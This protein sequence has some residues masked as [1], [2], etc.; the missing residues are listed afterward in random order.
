[1]KDALLT[2]IGAVIGG[3]G[4]D[5]GGA[6]AEMAE[7]A[8]RDDGEQRSCA[9]VAPLPAAGGAAAEAA[10]AAAAAAEQLGVARPSSGPILADCL[11]DVLSYHNGP[12]PSARQSGM[13]HAVAAAAADNGATIGVCGSRPGGR[14]RRSCARQ[15]M[16]DATD[17][18]NAAA[19]LDTNSTEGPWVNQQARWKRAWVAEGCIQDF[20]KWSDRNLAGGGGA[21]GAAALPA[22]WEAV[23]TANGISMTFVK[24]MFQVMCDPNGVRFGP[25]FDASV[26][27]DGA[28]PTY[29]RYIQ[30]GLRDLHRIRCAARSLRLLCARLPSACLPRGVHAA[31]PDAA[32]ACHRRPI[33]GWTS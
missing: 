7:R 6:A 4:A 17:V 3:A 23:W 31:R 21:E 9:G 1:V 27:V 11:A 29:L 8:P 12:R 28:N 22:G 14:A 32:G 20:R 26:P 25:T 15:A 5:V 18:A 13:D 30:E 2:L 19:A 10:A 24:V 16:R 33:P